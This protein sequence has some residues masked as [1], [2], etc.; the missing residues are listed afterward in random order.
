MPETNFHQLHIFH[1]VARLGSFSKAADDLSISQP[2]VSIQ[3]RELEATLGAPLI[4]RL[5]RGLQLTDT[6]EAVFGYTQRIFALSEEMRSAVQ[7]IQGLK[8]GR[9]TIGSSST[10]GEYI[11]PWAIG[12]FRKRYP[13]VE[14]SLAISNTQSIVERIINHELD[15][16]MAGATVSL[17][18][19]AS[20]T[21]VEDE[22]VIIASPEHP[23]AMAGNVS[24]EDL[25]GQEFILREEGSATRHTAEEYLSKSG[26]AIKV[27]ME[28]GSNEAVKRAVAA[29]LGLGVVSRYAVEPNTLIGFLTIV[30]VHG[31]DCHRPLTVFHRDDKNLPPA[32]KAFLEFLREQKPLPWEAS[33]GDA[34]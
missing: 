26:I 31:W 11:L 18:G 17:P 9:L 6:G 1:T 23:I 21:Y 24:M 14:V 8:A 16:G 28:L 2:A 19:L 27:N 20:F 7:D 15:L 3:V 5:R 33:E 25:I 13:G 4:H 30:E 34:P 22:I 32:Q 12:K 29:G 10:P